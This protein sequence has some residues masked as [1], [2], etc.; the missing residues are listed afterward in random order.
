[1]AE[2]A[3]RMKMFN[4]TLR[5]IPKF[6]GGANE[7]WH[8]HELQFKL[9]TQINGIEHIATA[10]Q[11]KMCVLHSLAGNATRAI[12]LHQPAIDSEITPADFLAK[13]REVFL[14]RA[15]SNLSRMD[16]EQH[17]WTTCHVQCPGQQADF[18]LAGLYLIICH[19]LQ[20][21]VTK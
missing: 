6:H 2:A 10:R 14:P 12:E 9:W 3:E 15:E 5:S 17:A 21:L 1:M 19:F 4:A 8:N 18:R 13:I 20:L 11:Q 7:R 16:F